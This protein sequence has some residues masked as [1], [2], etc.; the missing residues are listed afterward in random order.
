MPGHNV[1]HAK[2]LYKFC[3]ISCLTLGMA[4]S[5]GLAQ[6]LPE[7][8]S[9]DTAPSSRQAA[10]PAETET[11]LT[12]KYMLNWGSGRDWLADH[13]VTFDLHYIVDALDDV[14]AP[15]GGKSEFNTW[16]RVRATVDVDFGKFSSLDGLTYHAT[17]L[18]QSGQN[19]GGKQYVGSIANPSG[20]V[21]IHTFRLDS[22]WLQQALFD[23]KLTMTAGQMAAQDFFGLQDLGRNFVMEPLDYAFGNL[24]NVRA[25]ADPLTG[26]GGQVKFAPNDSVFVKA[27]YFMPRNYDDT[28]FGYRKEAGGLDRTGTWNI[29]FGYN[30]DPNAPASRKSYPGIV[31]VGLVYN[32]GQFVDYGKPLIG[33]SPQTSTS[34]YT[35]YVMATQPV[36]RLAPGSNRGL[37]LTLGVNTGPDKKSEVPTEITFGASFNGP[38]ASRPKDILSLGLV[39]SEISDKYN[40]YMISTKAST[41]TD[42]KA[43]E[44]NYLAQLTPWLYV[45]PVVQYYFNAGGLTG[46]DSDAVVTGFRLNVTF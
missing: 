30:T 33:G 46:E 27:G 13:G 42:E 29:E 1:H 17:G 7:N 14:Q 22:M 2:G 25:S 39:Y 24:G 11:L 6:A 20:L 23:G 26:P 37:D 40:D 18:W 35:A 19:M 31:H 32:Q 16:N 3:L 5:V 38:A 10:A 43:L 15:K 41:L 12:Q 45:Q 28:G 36:Y 21:S 44:L 34:N 4:P 8:G 9:A